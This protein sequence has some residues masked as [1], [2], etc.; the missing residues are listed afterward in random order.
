MRVIV[1]LTTEAREEMVQLLEGRMPQPADALVT[2]IISTED[3]IR[4]FE[5]H[6]G[7]P[8]EAT[9]R[10]YANREE[11]WWLYADGIWVGFT[12][13]TRLTWF[14]RPTERTIRVTAV[15]EQPGVL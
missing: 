3:V 4:T 7:P 15:A 13:S 2:A 8:P 12:T 6:G 10:R 14:R 11:V 1:E 9:L 5:T